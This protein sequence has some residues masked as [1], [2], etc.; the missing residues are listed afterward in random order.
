MAPPQLASRILI[1]RGVAVAQP[2][3][4][5]LGEPLAA[6]CAAEEDRE[7]VADQLAAAAGEDR[8]QGG[9]ARPMLL[10]DVGRKPPDQAAVRKHGTAD[11]GAGDG[12]D[13]GGG[14]SE[15]RRL[16]GEG[17]RGVCGM[18]WKDRISRFWVFRAGR[19]W[20]FAEPKDEAR[21]KGSQKLQFG[22]KQL[23]PRDNLTENRGPK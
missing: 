3:R 9:Q 2:D 16:G 21:R 10:A 1:R 23:A 19:N 18:R 11:R 12:V 14:C 7:L 17:R 15:I 6:V 13:G 4:L 5:Q 8:R 20:S 22:D